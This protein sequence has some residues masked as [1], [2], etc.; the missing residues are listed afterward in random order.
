M[1]SEF[2]A[3]EL[4]EKERECEKAVVIYGMAIIMCLLWVDEC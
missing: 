1:S 3:T 4:F 2:C